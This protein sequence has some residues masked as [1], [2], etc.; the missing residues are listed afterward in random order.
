M[1]T[2]CTVG[3]CAPLLRESWWSAIG[4]FAS[5]FPSRWQSAWRALF[6]E[7]TS[8]YFQNNYWSITHA[9]AITQRRP[10]SPTHVP[11]QP[12]GKPIVPTP[13]D[14]WL[15]RCVNPPRRAGRSAALPRDAPVQLRSGS[16]DW[17]VATDR[18]RIDA[19][20]LWVMTWWVR[21]ANQMWP[22][23]DFCCG[24]RLFRGLKNIFS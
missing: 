20:C 19:T 5:M 10:G 17:S 18:A 11:S 13:L 4:P 6:A 3:Y 7:V 23:P 2:I 9:L 8:R 12:A 1:P 21:A 16:H 24:Q 14:R 15:W 22:L